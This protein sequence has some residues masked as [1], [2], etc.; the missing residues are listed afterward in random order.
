MT[1]LTP[2]QL[3]HARFVAARVIEHVRANPSTLPLL[4]ETVKTVGETCRRG[5][6]DWAYQSG[7]RYCAVCRRQ[8][9][10]KGRAG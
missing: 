10:R 5:H 1:A 9:R 6:R 7:E 3:A 8:R 2:D 4:G